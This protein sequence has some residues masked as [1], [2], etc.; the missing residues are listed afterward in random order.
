[1]HTNTEIKKGMIVKHKYI[2]QLLTVVADE[3][4]PAYTGEEFKDDE[5]PLSYAIQEYKAGNLILPNTDNREEGKELFTPGEWICSKE[6]GKRF[7]S[8]NAVNI[9][10]EPQT[11]AIVYGIGTE[12]EATAQLI[13]ASKDLYFALKQNHSRLLKIY[14]RFGPEMSEEELKELRSEMKHTLEALFKANPNY[15]P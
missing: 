15:K 14:T 1:M 4:G 7:G 3:K 10:D 2:E 8:F 12:G 6:Q 11:V 13:A 5:I 9:K